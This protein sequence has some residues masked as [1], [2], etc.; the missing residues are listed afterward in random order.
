MSTEE[1]IKEKYSKNHH[2]NLKYAIMGYD[3]SFKNVDN[4]NIEDSN[5]KVT[6]TDITSIFKVI[7]SGNF[8]YGQIKY[9]V[10]LVLNHDLQKTI[11]TSRASFEPMINR[12]NFIRDECYISE[13]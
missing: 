7:V 12:Y 6:S 11:R 2:N 9:E 1:N 10:K 3:N 4:I 8:I 13:L 5:I